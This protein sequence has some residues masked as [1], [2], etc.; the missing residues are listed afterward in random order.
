[1]TSFNR[2]ARDGYQQPCKACLAKKRTNRRKTQADRESRSRWKKTDAG[3]LSNR[4]AVATWQAKPENKAR[5][6]AWNESHPDNVRQHFTNWNRK[7]QYLRRAS[8][9]LT[10]IALEALEERQ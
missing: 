5:R 9:A 7:Q 3:K 4:R 2:H 8:K 1:A 6:R 10:M